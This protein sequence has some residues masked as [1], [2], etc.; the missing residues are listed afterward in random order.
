M[1]LIK[2]KTGSV[3]HLITLQFRRMLRPYI[4]YLRI[5]IIVITSVGTYVF[6]CKLNNIKQWCSNTYRIYYITNG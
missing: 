1:I 6:L 3:F 5:Y 2:K 4:Y